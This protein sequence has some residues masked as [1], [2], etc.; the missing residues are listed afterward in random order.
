LALVDQLSENTWLS[1]DAKQEAMRKI[2]T[3]KLALVSPNNEE[4]WNFNPRADYSTD[5]PIAN[6]LKLRKLL[7]DKHLNELNGPININRWHMGPLTV[8]AN[9]DPSH[10]R[11][12]F[13]VGILQYPYYD[14][15]EPEEVNLAAIGA[16]IGHELGHAIDDHG[17]GFNADGILRSWM[18]DEDKKTFDE[19]SRP[20]VEQ[21]NKIGHNGKFTLGENIGDLVGLRTVYRAAFS[22]ENDNSQELKKRFFLQFARFL[23]EVQREKFAEF[24]LKV[25]PHSLGYARANEQIKQQEGF[26]EAYNCKPGDPMVLPK[27]EIVNIW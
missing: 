6:I 15:N 8:N 23:C 2:K 26:K 14:A 22:K 12:E 7:M 17:S 18:L 20:L 4:E 25:D 13:P 16:V 11:F 9:Y 5:S 3:A 10:N 19:K 24:R 27:N 21:F 1:K